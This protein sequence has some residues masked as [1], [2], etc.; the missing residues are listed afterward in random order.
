MPPKG[1]AMLFVLAFGLSW[2]WDWLTTFPSTREARNVAAMHYLESCP[3]L[4]GG[5]V[6]VTQSC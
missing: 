2:G 5:S 6:Q 3:L 1:L 4:Q